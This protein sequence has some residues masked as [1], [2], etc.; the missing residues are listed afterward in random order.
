MD[1]VRTCPI[2]PACNGRKFRI[3]A[4]YEDGS[5]MLECLRCLKMITIL[6]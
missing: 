3:I 5:V 2:C 1:K 6:S 4:K